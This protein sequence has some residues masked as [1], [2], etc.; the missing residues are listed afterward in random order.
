[1]RNYETK[2]DNSSERKVEK[3]KNPVAFWRPDGNL[4][5]KYGYF[6]GEKKGLKN[7]V[8]LVLFFPPT[9]HKSPFFCISHSGVFLVAKWQKFPKKKRCL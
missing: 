4:F 3:F 5:S 9:P 8:T 7:L 1:M 2:F 6:I